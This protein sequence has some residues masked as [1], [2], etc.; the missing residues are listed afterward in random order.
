MQEE[1][2]APWPGGAGTMLLRA[3]L[4]WVRPQ[5]LAPRR[6]LQHQPGSRERRSLCTES[7]VCHVD[8]DVLQEQDGL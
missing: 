5:A 2:P 3:Q 7:S 8:S 1:P 4:G 6:E